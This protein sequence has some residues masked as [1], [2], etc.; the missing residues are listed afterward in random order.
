MTNADKVINPQH[1]GRDPADIR[2]RI[3]PAIPIGILDHFWLKF[4][5]W[6]SLRFLSEVL[7]SPIFLSCFVEV[8]SRATV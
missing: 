7:T 1:F 5:Q 8:R 6:W 2:I 4:W 3:N